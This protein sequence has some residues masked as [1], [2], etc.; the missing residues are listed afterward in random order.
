MPCRAVP[1]ARGLRASARHGGF[2]RQCETD[3]ERKFAKKELHVT[4]TELIS[5]GPILTFPGRPTARL[6]I[7][8]DRPLATTAVRRNNGENR[9]E[10]HEDFKEIEIKA[11]C[12]GGNPKK[13]SYIYGSPGLKPV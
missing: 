10:L 13:P 4:I 9:F 8:A 2:A 3:L 12:M 5:N 7:G 1:K 11:L 6:G